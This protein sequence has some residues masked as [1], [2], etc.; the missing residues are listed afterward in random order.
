MCN[1]KRIYTLKEKIEMYNVRKSEEHNCFYCKKPLTEEEI[2]IDHIVPYGRGG[3]T[4]KENLVISCSYC[5]REKA[6]M[7]LDEYMRF[8]EI[9]FKAIK[10]FHLEIEENKLEEMLNEIRELE[11]VYK[12]SK[13][14]YQ[15]FLGAIYN[16]NIEKT[17]NTQ[18]LQRLQ[19]LLWKNKTNLTKVNRLFEALET[20][21]T[22]V[23]LK[24]IQQ[25]LIV[26][27]ELEEYYRMLG[28]LKSGAVQNYLRDKL[29]LTKPNV[30]VNIIG[31]NN[32]VTINI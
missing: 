1:N 32:T 28:N 17:D 21:R 7:D 8:L 13:S 19:F 2:T 30:D 4:S 25:E 26:K 24:K 31:N 20:Q 6:D 5:N 22:I 11:G 18:I 10:N 16:Y 23:K 14:E 29:N 9:K 15:S 27:N 3:K 12:N